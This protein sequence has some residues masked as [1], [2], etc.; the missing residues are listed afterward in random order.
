MWCKAVEACLSWTSWALSQHLI[1]P[2]DLHH[3]TPSSTKPTKALR[4]SAEDP[5]AT[6]GGAIAQ[7]S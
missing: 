4:S 6:K 7:D 2:G 5:A 1:T 3:V